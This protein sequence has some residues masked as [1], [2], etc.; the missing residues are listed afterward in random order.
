MSEATLFDAA[1][2]PV[3]AEPVA[4]VKRGRGRP[5]IYTGALLSHMIAVITA[6]GL[7]NGRKLLNANGIILYN[8]EKK[9]NFKRDRALAPKGLGV[10]MVTLCKM[11]QTHGVKL[12]RGRPKLDKKAA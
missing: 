10:S 6:L 2:E 9:F 7:T 5:A 8:L 1:V 12:V 3:V 4:E 11:G